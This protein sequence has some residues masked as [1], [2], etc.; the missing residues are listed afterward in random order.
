MIG[1]ANL[2]EQAKKSLSFEQSE[3]L[4]AEQRPELCQDLSIGG[5]VP[6]PAATTEL[7]YPIIHSQASNMLAVKSTTVAAAFT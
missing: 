4:R 6:I 5:L 3:V 2:Q 1:A 7:W